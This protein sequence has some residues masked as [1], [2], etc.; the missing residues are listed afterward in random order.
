[1]KQSETNC[2]Q[3]VLPAARMAIDDSADGR[4]S[5]SDGMRQLPTVRLRSG[6]EQTPA[7]P[8]FAIPVEAV[9]WSLTARLG[10]GLYRCFEFVVALFALILL[11]PL[12]L[13]A[14]LAVRLNSAGP[15]L[16]FHARAGRS[17]PTRGRD[18]IGR[19]DLR[20]PQG[21]FEPDKLY[22][23]PTTFMLAKFRTMS[24]EK[25]DRFPQLEWWKHDVD[26]EECQK[27][28]YKLDDDPRV[29]RVG[30]LLRKTSINELPNLWNVLTGDIG[31]VGPRPEFA[32][33]LRCYSPEQMHKFTVKPGLTCLAEVNGRNDLP[34]GEHIAWDLEYVRSRSFLLDMKI[35]F[36]TFWVVLG[37][38]GAS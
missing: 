4:Q 34:V 28:H 27:K 7:R 20:P 33:F 38:K 31:L 16:F 22:W 37:R 2:Q 1:M 6:Q 3:T 32:E 5:A 9:P 10:Q 26:P 35:L 14:A 25:A 17:V 21:E 19:S 36:R 13:I 8:V 11:S 12:L 15:A 29:T 18:L 23:V 30:K 24:Q